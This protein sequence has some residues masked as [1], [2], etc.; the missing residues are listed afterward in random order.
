MWKPWIT[1]GLVALKTISAPLGT[2]MGLGWYPKEKART[3][4]VYWLGPV[5]TTALAGS[6]Q[7]PS[8][9]TLV[10]STRSSWPTGI[11][12]RRPWLA[13]VKAMMAVKSRTVKTEKAIQL[14]LV[15]QEGLVLSWA[16]R[17][18]MATP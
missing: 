10:G 16:S 9:R 4:T 14:L 18:V 13:R 8:L 3:Y 7:G 15:S 17:S 11:T 2:T 1:S 12:P 5:C 6:A